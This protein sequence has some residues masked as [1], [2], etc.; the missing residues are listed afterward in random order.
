MGDLDYL[1]GPINK[2]Y[3][4]YF[5]ILSIVGFVY[6]AGFLISGVFIGLS[7]R[8]TFEY[9]VMLVSGALVFFLFYFQNRLLYTMCSQS[10]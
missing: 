2:K 10:L 5:Y 7:K 8:K 3:C 4:L 9:Y 6:F 1:F